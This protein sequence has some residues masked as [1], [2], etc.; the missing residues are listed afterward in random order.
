MEIVDDVGVRVV[1]DC[2]SFVDEVEDEEVEAAEDTAADVELALDA[3]LRTC[4]T[5]VMKAWLLQW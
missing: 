2:E 4:T 1:D 5:P 3:P